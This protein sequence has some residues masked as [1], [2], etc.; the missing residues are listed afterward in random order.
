MLGIHH[1]SILLYDLLV[2]LNDFTGILRPVA[3]LMIFS[4][5]STYARAS[6]PVSQPA[7]QLVNQ[8]TGQPVSQ[9]A[10]KRQN[11]YFRSEFEGLEPGPDGG[12][13]A[14]AYKNY[15]IMSP[16]R[17]RSTFSQFASALNGSKCLF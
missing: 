10:S 2:S 17:A 11:A 4:Q 1:K 14:T 3:A 9:S 8:S 16:A 12:V 5:Q 15:E 7:S 13:R 6:S